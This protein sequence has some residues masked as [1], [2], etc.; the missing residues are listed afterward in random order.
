MPPEGGWYGIKGGF[1]MEYHEGLLREL[2]RAHFGDEGMMATPDETLL[3]VLDALSIAGASVEQLAGSALETGFE[4]PSKEL[5]AFGMKLHIVGGSIRK[6]G[7]GAKELIDE[8]RAR[9]RGEEVDDGI[10]VEEGGAFVHKI[11]HG[12]CESCPDRTGCDDE[13]E[14][15]QKAMD[16]VLKNSGDE[17]NA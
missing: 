4:G 10:S 9:N 16:E 2:L 7:D 5:I 15:V 13:L 12:D 1:E 6:A 8:G 17:E 14:R 11:V 3:L